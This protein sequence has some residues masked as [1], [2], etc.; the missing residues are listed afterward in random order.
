MQLPNL[1][2]LSNTLS[3]AYRTQNTS[4]VEKLLYKLLYN[5]LYNT[6]RTLENLLLALAKL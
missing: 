2:L 1:I 6:L 3:A 5:K 4:G